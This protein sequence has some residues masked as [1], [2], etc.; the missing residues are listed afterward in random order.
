[1]RLSPT[2]SPLRKYNGDISLP[3][4][5][6]NKTMLYHS[7]TSAASPDPAEKESNIEELLKDNVEIEINAQTLIFDENPRLSNDN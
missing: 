3:Q 7:I 6:S 1:M 5:A 2:S 4:I